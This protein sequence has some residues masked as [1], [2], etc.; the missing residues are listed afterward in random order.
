MKA[1]INPC[2]WWHQPEPP[3]TPL[4][5]VRVAADHLERGEVV[6]ERAAMFISTA[7]RQYLAGQHDITKN[8]GLRPR[9]GLPHEVARQRK[10]DRDQHIKAIFERQPGNRS[11]RARQTAALLATQPDELREI[12]EADVMGHLFELHREHGGDLPRS[13]E[14][15][16]RIAGRDVES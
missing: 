3:L 10:D 2:A 16:L 7:L 12:T 13:W 15:V 1:I 4:E 6:P 11:E 8:L 5:A 9:R 14:H